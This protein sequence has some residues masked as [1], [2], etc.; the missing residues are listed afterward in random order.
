M[1]F[2]NAQVK[3]MFFFELKIPSSD[4]SALSSRG[5]PKA[6]TKTFIYIYTLTELFE[7]KVVNSQ[8]ISMETKK[9]VMNMRAPP[10]EN[11][12]VFNQESSKV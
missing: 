5:T 2:N 6:R 3:Q 9:T 10:K 8:M 11:L 12:Q 1:T 7:Q 4:K